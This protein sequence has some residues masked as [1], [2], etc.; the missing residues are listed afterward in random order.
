MPIFT[1]CNSI[2]LIGYIPR[3]IQEHAKIHRIKKGIVSWNKSKGV[4][5]EAEKDTLG[6]GVE[7]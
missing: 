4:W 7:S 1:L 5:T 2:A 3:C 6:W